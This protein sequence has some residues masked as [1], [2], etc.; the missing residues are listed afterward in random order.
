MYIA[1]TGLD[2]PGK[3]SGGTGVMPPSPRAPSAAPRVVAIQVTFDGAC[4]SELVRRVVDRELVQLRG[5]PAPGFRRCSAP[6]GVDAQKRGCGE[7]GD[8]RSRRAAYERT[9][10]D[11]P[12]R[13][14]DRR[15]PLYR[16]GYLRL[17]QEDSARCLVL[18]TRDTA[19][20]HEQGKPVRNSA[21]SGTSAPGGRGVIHKRLSRR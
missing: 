9:G 12:L 20:L 7:D 11:H 18:E 1:Y 5:K 3:T 2:E 17:D 13:S 4:V 8:R 15:H 14:R 16:R 10:R 6:G 19:Q 21:P